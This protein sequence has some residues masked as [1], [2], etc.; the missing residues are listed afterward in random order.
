[1]V[2]HRGAWVLFSLV[3]REPCLEPSRPLR[4]P[5][6]AC[7]HGDIRVVEV[8]RYVKPIRYG[9][10]VPPFRWVTG[11]PGHRLPFSALPRL[12]NS[13]ISCVPT[14]LLTGGTVCLIMVRMYQ[15]PSCSLSPCRGRS[16]S[17]RVLD[18][19][20]DSGLSHSDTGQP[21]GLPRPRRVVTSYV[22]RPPPPSI[23]R[24]TSMPDV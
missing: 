3:L 20:H 22:L 21:P 23:G 6:I 16:K 12:Q 10:C 2:F 19:D 5:D 1:M 17:W 11:H 14:G 9:S 18:D 7:N 13:L 4:I 24:V 15:I 8:R